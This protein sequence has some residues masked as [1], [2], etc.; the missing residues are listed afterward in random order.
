MSED[1]DYIK[2]DHSATALD[3]LVTAK[4]KDNWSVTAQCR[5]ALFSIAHSL[6]ALTELLSKDTENEAC[7]E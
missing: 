5:H 4:Q 3:L 7:D 2:Y 1:V 6:I